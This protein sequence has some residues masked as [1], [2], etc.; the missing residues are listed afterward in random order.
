M[1]G[2]EARKYAVDHRKVWGAVQFKK[3]LREFQRA[4]G[5]MEDRAWLRREI[6]DG[7]RNVG[8]RG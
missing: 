6:E 4:L 3:N 8:C 2:R 1:F 7:D 5:Q